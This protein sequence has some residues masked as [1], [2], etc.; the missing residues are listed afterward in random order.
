MSLPDGPPTPLQTAIQRPGRDVVDGFRALSPT[1]VADVLVPANVVHRD[2]HALWGPDLPTVAGPAF[3][4]RVGRHDNLMLHAAIYL[5]EPGDVIV[6][7]AGD[8]EMAVAGGNVCAIAQ[9]RGVAAFV[10]DGVVRDVGE[11]RTR[12]FPLFARGRSPIAAKRVGDG[13]V[14]LEVRCGG[15]AVS[16][17]DIVVAGAEG[18]VVVP[19]AAAAEVLAR[20]QVKADADRALDLDAWQARHR[21]QVEAAL[22]LRGLS[23]PP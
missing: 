19:R 2:V 5:A 6:V 9:R 15:A 4:V 18:I 16:A 13:G 23:L 7:E 1:E 14:G 10:V 11:S 3:T 8:D 17:G 20:A 21:G 12:A 22:R